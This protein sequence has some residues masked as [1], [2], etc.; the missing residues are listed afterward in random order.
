VLAGY[1]LSPETK[2]LTM[3]IVFIHNFAFALLCAV[4]SALPN[5]LRAAGEVKWVMWASLFSTVV[6]RVFFS[7]FFGIK[8]G[9]GV[10]GITLAMVVD[11]SIKAMLVYL[12]Y[13]SGIWLEKKVIK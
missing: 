4:H 1:A 11:W 2:S 7:W 12:R 9:W 8:L 3:I 13:H 10:I 5:G 6:C